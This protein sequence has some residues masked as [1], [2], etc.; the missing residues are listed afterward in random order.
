MRSNTVVLKAVNMIVVLV[1]S[2]HTE[3]VYYTQGS[4]TPPL[5]H[6]INLLTHSINLLTHSTDLYQLTHLF[7]PQ[8][9]YG[10][11]PFRSDLR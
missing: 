7:L 6:S 4:P 8:A 10:A 1:R 9:V 5:T 11:A 3:D 2:H